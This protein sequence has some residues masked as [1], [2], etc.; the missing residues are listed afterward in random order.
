MILQDL[1]TIWI[2]THR[3]V[4]VDGEMQDFY[5][6][7]H[8]ELVNLQTVSDKIEVETY[9]EVTNS[10]IIFRTEHLPSI[11]KSDHIYLEVPARAGIVELDGATYENYPPGQYAV[12]SVKPSYLGGNHINNP[13][14]ITAKAVT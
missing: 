7:L 9:G 11:H 13:T 5:T 2:S 3:T 14:V 6:D 8:T 4:P 10:V 1:S 12:E